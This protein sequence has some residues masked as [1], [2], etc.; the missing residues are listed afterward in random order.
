MED[1]PP[2]RLT[3]GCQCGAVR[4]A[5]S[6]E[7]CD[8]SVCHCRMCQKAVGGPFAALAGVSRASLTWT[9]GEPAR[10]ASSSLATRGFCAACGTPLTYEGVSADK[11]DITVCSLDN[12]LAAPPVR[13]YGIEGRVAWLD[14]ID[15]LPAIETEGFYAGLVNHQHPDRDE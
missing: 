5:L 12:P 7:P 13:A 14:R 15:A 2:F 11:I 6:A 1:D 10:F 4:Y 8:S 3:G 9:R